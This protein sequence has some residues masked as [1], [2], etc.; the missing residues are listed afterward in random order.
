MLDSDLDLL[1][2]DE[3]LNDLG[4]SNLDPLPAHLD[5]DRLSPCDMFNDSDLTDFID[6]ESSEYLDQEVGLATGIENTDEDS[7]P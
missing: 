1:D 6:D 7:L 2:T 4:Y 3:L 5:H